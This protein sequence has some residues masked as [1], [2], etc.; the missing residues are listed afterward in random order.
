MIMK[1]R[2]TLTAIGLSLVVACGPE[3]AR[4]QEP[5]QRLHQHLFENGDFEEGDPNVAPPGW[6][7]KTYLNP[8]AG[9]TYPPT[10]RDDLKLA[11]G[12]SP[13]TITLET[14]NGPES[15]PDEDMGVA[16]SLRWPK[17]GNKVAVVNRKSSGRNV[18]S[19]VQKMTI[20]TSD[21]DPSDGRAHVRFALAPVLQNPGHEPEEQPYYFVQL[22]NVTKDTVLYQ[23]FNASAQPGVPWKYVGTGGNQISYTDWQLV[24]IAPGDA[25]MGV[26]DEVELEVIAA[27]CAQTGHFGRVYVDGVGATIPGLYV[28]G[29]GPSGANAGDHITY[30]LSYANGGTGSAVGT[31]VKFNVPDQTTWV[32]LDAPGLSC[33]GPEDG[34]VSC[35][36]GTVAP[37]GSGNLYVT[38]KIDPTATGL[39]TAGHY[40]IEATNSSALLGP[41]IYTNVTS[42]V[43]YADLDITMT[44]HVGGVAWGQPVTYDIVVT[45]HGPSAV[46]GA[47]IQNMM[48]AE[49]TNVSWSCV[50]SGTGKCTDE[51][52][53]GDIDTTIDLPVDGT[54]TFQVTAQVIAGSGSG[55]L[56]N[57]ATVAP[58]ASVTDPFPTNDTAVDSDMIGTLRTTTVSKYG[59]LGTVVSTPAAINCG[60]SCVSADGNFVEGMTVTLN[61]LPA[62]GSAFQ[63][64][65]GACSGTATSCTFTVGEDAWVA[66]IFSTVPRAPG[67]NCSSDD[68]CTTNFCVDGVCCDSACG[69]G[70]DDCQSCAVPDSVGT[71]TVL[72]QGT[73]CSA[74]GCQ[75]GVLTPAATCDGQST[76]CQVG[77]PQSC[78]G[79]A[80][81]DAGSCKGNCTNNVD[82]VSGHYC[83]VD[84]NECKVLVSQGDACTSDVQCASGNCVDDVCCNTPC[85]GQC[86]ACNLAAAPGVCLPVTGSPLG[87][88]PACDTD[89]S[90]CGGSCNGGLRTACTYPGA[91]TQCGQPSCSDGVATLAALCDGLGGC[92]EPTTQSCGEY[93]CGETECLGD[94]AVDENCAAGHFCSG[95]MCAEQ[96][97]RGDACSRDAQCE[98]GYCVDDVCCD[99]GCDGQCEACDVAGQEGTCSPVQGQPHGARPACASDGS[100]CGGSCDGVLTTACVY[101]TVECRAAECDAGV[102][103]LAASCDGAGTCPAEQLQDC[104]SF[105]CG[106]TA[107][108]GNCTVDAECA[109]GSYCSA[110]VCTLKL[111]LGV[112]CSGD[113]Q[114]A[115]GHCVD[116]V[117]CDG[118]CTG[119]CE[120][121][122][123]A[124]ALGT[125]SPV[126]G[127]PHGARTQ[128]GSDGSVCGGS[129]DG[130]EREACSYPAMETECRAAT[131]SDGVATLAATCDGQGS[132]PALLEQDCGNFLCGAT[133]CLGDC[134]RTADC[135]TG[136]YCSAG[137]CV[138][139]RENGQTCS[140]NGQCASGHCVDGVCCD[141]ACTGQ[142]A[143]CDLAGSEG[144]CSPVLG[145]PRNGRAACLGE[146]D[147]KGSCDGENMD[148]CTF[149]GAE[150]TCREGS[151]ASGFETSPAQCN[152]AGLCSL[153][154]T[155]SCGAYAC[156]GDL[157]ATTCSRAADCAPGMYCV[158]GV[159]QKD[160][161]ADVVPNHAGVIQGG[162]FGCST[163]SGRP[164]GTP[165][166]WMLGA[167][168]LG[169]LALLRR[170]GTSVTL[171]R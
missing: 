159:C 37:G 77:A 107:C 75:D 30:R 72:S 104:G 123:V 64:W 55:T 125:C 161:P 53:T 130:V 154:T 131:C 59:G 40:E 3:S 17:Y 91:G 92:N 11:N 112:A 89:G 33:T 26:G 140:D 108:L 2:S 151:C 13:D 27:R 58:P 78:G 122:D 146:G 14:A 150:V 28:S 57:T 36:V 88:R 120:A 80:C 43:D 24:D 126:S 60:P 145:A 148:E 29:T 5:S 139:E 47:S 134:T 142:C 61:A 44:N 171:T 103:T 62:P 52:G 38:V 87:G 32:G 54:A 83:D 93:E 149:P 94:C 8:S 129:C 79:L 85:E 170:R 18:N 115:S 137:V 144:T 7:V 66:A 119:Q 84:T 164:G 155:T 138:P 158:E 20:T 82:C 162:G 135:A 16:A 153:G 73:T 156:A 133:A 65:G 4:E 113:N 143:A 51:D 42:E 70:I 90:V 116:G 81:E 121:C 12:G 96:L 128:C 35:T 22:R 124:G 31:V 165:F 10:S 15:E 46:V 86:E 41:K 56:K 39:I 163:T 76:E 167:G 98:S 1:T 21:I 110:G 117:C 68:Q 9:V 49:L 67:E 136:S 152:G 118:G 100:V 109:D 127:A 157:C 25:G 97:E 99:G 63:G 45:N 48:P 6:T 111:E 95:G 141:T 69:G 168:L 169:G 101:P 74:A 71:C 166:G 160:P 50:A 147:C 132:C 23:D 105:L 19:L 114:C 34:E 106:A 102:A